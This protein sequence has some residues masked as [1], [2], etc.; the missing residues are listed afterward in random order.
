MA[1]AVPKPTEDTMTEP[2]RV[3]DLTAAAQ[4]GLEDVPRTRLVRL[5][6]AA[7]REPL[8]SGRRFGNRDAIEHDVAERRAGSFTSDGE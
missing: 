3:D 4:A 6:L 2:S 8:A 7:R 1:K 5:L